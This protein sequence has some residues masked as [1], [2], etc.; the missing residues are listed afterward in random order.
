MKG[1]TGWG[2]LAKIC[3]IEAATDIVGGEG[4]AEGMKQS[5]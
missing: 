3:E 2:S 4:R 1:K 5:T